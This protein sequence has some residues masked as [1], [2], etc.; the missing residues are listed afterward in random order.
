MPALEIGQVVPDFT[1]AM[2]GETDFTLSDYR[3]KSN[4][5]LYF[6]PKDSTL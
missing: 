1:A 3:G 4:V 6:Y 2:T 5:I